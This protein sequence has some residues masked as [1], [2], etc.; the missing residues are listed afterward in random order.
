MRSTLTKM[1][2]L[3]Q[4]FSRPIQ[5]NDCPT[6]WVMSWVGKLDP[7]Y[8]SIRQGV[9]L[10][11][12][13]LA[14]RVRLLFMLLALCVYVS[15]LFVCDYE[16]FWWGGRWE[17]YLFLAGLEISWGHGVRGNV[18]SKLVFMLQLV[19]Y[20]LMGISVSWFDHYEQAMFSPLLINDYSLFIFSFIWRFHFHLK[21]F[22]SLIIMLKSIFCCFDRKLVW[23]ECCYINFVKWYLDGVRL[24][25]KKKT[26]I[27]NIFQV[28][29]ATLKN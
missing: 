21:C 19:I 23:N 7:R 11:N 9:V 22:T 20:R 17:V 3:T 25:H 5:I 28:N 2:N 24:L 15:I 14:M 8:K 27:E 6:H 29:F 16:K 18:V 10:Y 1:L 12:F 13:F 4:I 26:L